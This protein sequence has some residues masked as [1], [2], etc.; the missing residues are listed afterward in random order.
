MLCMVMANIHRVMAWWASMI[1]YKVQQA[2]VMQGGELQHTVCGA[3]PGAGA[4]SS[5]SHQ[6]A[7]GS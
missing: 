4:G 3:Q 2:C 7:A 6:P 5:T 1:A